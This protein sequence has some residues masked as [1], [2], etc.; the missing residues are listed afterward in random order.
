M[1]SN[2]ETVC[3]NPS[4][5]AS[6]HPA[7]PTTN[8]NGHEQDPDRPDKVQTMAG[9]LMTADGFPMAYE[10]FPGNTA[11]VETFTTMRACRCE[12]SNPSVRN[13]AGV[14]YWNSATN[15]TTSYSDPRSTFSHV[16]L[17]PIT[18]PNTE[19]LIELIA[20]RLNRRIGHSRPGSCGQSRYFTRLL[21]HRLPSVILRGVPRW[22]CSRPCGRR[23]A[24]L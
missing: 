10:V 19:L 13:Q 4:A 22:D 24:P 7:C 16:R 11:G 20:R 2:C 3:L 21:A 1:P 8:R 23:T 12:V 15:G 5:D 18:M 6:L 17:H 9:V 14:R